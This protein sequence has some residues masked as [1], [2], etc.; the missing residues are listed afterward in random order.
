YLAL[1][2]VVPDRNNGW[3]VSGIQHNESNNPT[4]WLRHIGP[5]GTEDRWPIS[6]VFVYFY[7]KSGTYAKTLS[8]NNLGAQS[9]AGDTHVTMPIHLTRMGI[10]AAPFLHSEIFANKP[11]AGDTA[12]A[13]EQ[14]H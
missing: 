12:F 10:V 13:W 14:L 6:A 1:P 7:A 11:A 3:F 4:F 9:A 8:Y 5:D 2:Q